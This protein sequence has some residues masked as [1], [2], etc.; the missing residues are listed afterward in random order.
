MSGFTKFRAG[1]TAAGC[2]AIIFTGATY[3]AGLKTQKEWKEERKNFWESPY[4]EQ[5]SLLEGQ[6]GRLVTERRNWERKLTYLE[7]RIKER[8]PKRPES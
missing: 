4:D 3:G 2:A 7:E 5:I 8:E 6:R 1:L